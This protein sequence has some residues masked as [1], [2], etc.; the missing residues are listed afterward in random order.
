MAL[1][2]ERTLQ[3]GSR[4]ENTIYSYLLSVRLLTGFLAERGHDLTVA[5]TRD[6][7]KDFL[8]EQQTRRKI[9]D[10]RGRVRWGGSPATALVRYKSL[11]QFFKHCVEE[12]EL[13]VSPMV[14][15]PEPVPEEKPVPIV[16]DEVLANLLKARSGKSFVDRRDT[17][18]MRVFLDTGCRLAEVTNL[19]IGDVELKEGVLT[20][21]GKGNRLRTV[22]FGASTGK[23]VNSYIVQLEKEQPERADDPSGKLWIGRQGPLSTSGMTDVLH[24]MCD[25]AG[26]AHL[27]WH[28]FRH[29]LAHTWLAHGGTEGDLMSLAGWRSRAMLDRY[30][31][32]AQVERAH[33]A[34][35]RMTLG[36]RV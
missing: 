16:R 22:P 25:D 18:I 2:L 27:H 33:A 31:K 30:A 36:D 34:A 12:G 7:I 11:Q 9:V 32:S 14:G 26:I 6:D 35:K 17:A 24:R 15:I 19:R 3:T 23:A 28:Q 4:S 29:T 8:I 20:V 10:S 21:T 13:E 5:V 1:S